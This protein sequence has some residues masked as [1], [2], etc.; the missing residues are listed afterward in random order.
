MLGLLDRE[1]A[2]RFELGFKV[3]STEYVAAMRNDSQ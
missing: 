1:Y 3:R 2:A